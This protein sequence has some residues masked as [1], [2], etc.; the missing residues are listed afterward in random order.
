MRTG[1]RFHDAIPRRLLR[2][3]ADT[4]SLEQPQSKGARADRTAIARAPKPACNHAN[5]LAGQ[6]AEFGQPAFQAERS[7]PLGGHHGYHARRCAGLEV[8]Q[9]HVDGGIPGPRR[10]TQS[11]YLVRTLLGSVSLMLQVHGLSVYE[12][13]SHYYSGP[14]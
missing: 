5:R 2:A 14:R 13:R 10:A 7:R 3:N 9:L 1:Q 6:E 8:S 12:N 4:G 11:I